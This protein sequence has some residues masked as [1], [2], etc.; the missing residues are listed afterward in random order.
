MYI[1]PFWCGAIAVLLAEAAVCGLLIA[2]AIKS[3]LN[4]EEDETNEE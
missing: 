4:V 2:I 1:E 3:N